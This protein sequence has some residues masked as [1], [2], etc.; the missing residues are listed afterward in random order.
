MVATS[1]P[2]R[3]VLLMIILT[4]LT[5]AIYMPIWC[6]RRI[7]WLNSLS[8]SK[9]LGSRLP[10]FAL[11]IF[12]VSAFILLL[13]IGIEDV[14]IINVLDAIDEFINLA[15]G[16]TILVIAFKIRGILDEH[17]N[18]NLNMGISFSGVATFFFT[19]YYLQYKINR[20]PESTA[21][22]A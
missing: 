8:G 12:C 17:F 21:S 13:E 18:K 9:K 1:V 3:S 16:A 7:G 20:L 19:F 11:V 14:A 2:R 15:G 6:L 5:Y 10:I 4:I 22:V